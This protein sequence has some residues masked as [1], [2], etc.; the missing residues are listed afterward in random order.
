MRAIRGALIATGLFLT[1]CTH[2]PPRPA[3]PA[4]R[5]VVRRPTL[6]LRRPADLDAHGDVVIPRAAIVYRGGIP[7]VFVLSQHGRAR[8]RLIKIGATTTYR[9]E[10]LSGLNGN[11]TLVLPPFHGVYDGSPVHP[12]AQP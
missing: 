6:T 9:A 10:I 2:K 1:G 11:E 4:V 3:P 12:I 8:L 7:S 5:P